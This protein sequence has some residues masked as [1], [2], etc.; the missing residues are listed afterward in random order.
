MASE[1]LHDDPLGIESI[2]ILFSMRIERWIS[3]NKPLYDIP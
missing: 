2:I 1:Y 3:T